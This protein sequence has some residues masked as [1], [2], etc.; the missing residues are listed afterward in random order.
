LVGNT[1][2]EP[3]E[4]S[5]I[6][7]ETIKSVG[8][9]TE[10]SFWPQIFQFVKSLFKYHTWEF[11]THELKWNNLQLQFCCPD[12]IQ[13]AFSVPQQ[14]QNISDILNLL[15]QFRF[16]L[17]Q[18]STASGQTSVSRFLKF[19]KFKFLEHCN[20][21]HCTLEMASNYTGWS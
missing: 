15:R 5:G 1:W 4:I 3:C 2:W 13:G 10:S 19:S 16:G 18:G 12:T 20:W 8:G 21:R 14:H 17:L 11:Y 6:M 9:T 7:Q